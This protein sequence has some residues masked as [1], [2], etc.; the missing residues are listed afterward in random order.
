VGILRSRRRR[1]PPGRGRRDRGSTTLQFIILG[2]VFF[3]FILGIIQVAA[4]YHGRNVVAS[5]AQIGLQVARAQDATAAA[6]SSAAWGYLGT[7][8]P[9]YLTGLSVDASRAG[10]AAQ[11]Q[12]SSDPPQVIPLVPLPRISVA[13]SGP[14][15]V[16]T[17]P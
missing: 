4:Y 6:G 11:V 16:V 14:V 1:D 5:A 8:A 9:A 3:G 17:T 7:A 10:G 13:V 2:P 12:I 15:E